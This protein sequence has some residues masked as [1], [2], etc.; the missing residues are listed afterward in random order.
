MPA[1]FIS[2]FL[3]NPLV[4]VKSG[5]SIGVVT[6]RC[7]LSRPPCCWAQVCCKT[8]HR[9]QRY[10]QQKHLSCSPMRR[11][12]T[13]SIRCVCFVLI[14]VQSTPGSTFTSCDGLSQTSVTDHGTM[15]HL[16]CAGPLLAKYLPSVLHN[17][18]LLLTGHCIQKAQR[19]CCTGRSPQMMRCVRDA[20][21]L[22]SQDGKYRA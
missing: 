17:I 8:E 10:F 22:T 18:I 19:C 7:V 21:P 14:H 16:I 15:V 6:K 9:L 11:D 4:E 20:C 1:C 3:W 13:Q 12:Q 2:R 5:I